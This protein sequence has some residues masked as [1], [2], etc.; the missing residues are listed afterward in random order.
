MED[1]NEY[2]G[3]EVCECEWDWRCGL[4][5]GQYTPQ[6]LSNDEWAKREDCPWWAE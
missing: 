5:A 4:H 3:P 6:E 2:D 1:T